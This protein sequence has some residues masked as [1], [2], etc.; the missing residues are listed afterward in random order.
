MKSCPATSNKNSQAKTAF[1]VL[2]WLNLLPQMQAFE[3]RLPR[4]FEKDV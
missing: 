4:G 2:N 3:H 1:L